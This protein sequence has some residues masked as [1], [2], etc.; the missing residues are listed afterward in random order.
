MTHSMLAIDWLSLGNITKGQLELK[1]S[2][3]TN[4]VS[5]FVMHSSCVESLWYRR[6]PVL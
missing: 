5:S 6:E 4:L 1:R 2:Y 3:S